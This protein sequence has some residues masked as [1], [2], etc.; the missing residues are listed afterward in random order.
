ME[1]DHLPASVATLYAELL[2]Q[3]IAHER[4]AGLEGQLPGGL[5]SKE[6][7]GKRYLYWQ[8]R[9]GNQV[10]QRYLGP[11]SQDLREALD[12][13]ADKRQDSARQRAS[14]ERL[15][16]MLI[17]GGALREQPRVAAVLRL[18]ADLGLFRRGAVVVGTQAFRTYG[19][20]LSVRLPSTA[21]RTQDIDVAHGIDVALASTAE[22]APAVEA[23]L[24]TL[25]LLPVPGLHPRQP[26]T[27]FHLRGR[28]LRVDFLTPAPRRAKETPIPLPGL[29]LSAWPL[30]FLD[31]LIEDPV[32][33]VALDA[34]PVLLRVPRPG[35]YA[36]HK[37]WT[38]ATRPASEHAKATKDRAQAAA[39]ITVLA[40]ERPDDLREAYSALGRRR[41]ARQRVA[42]E[43]ARVAP[44]YRTWAS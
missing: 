23:S 20:M 32:P 29:G 38:A 12:R 18:L 40:S 3:E 22:E 25:G 43:L 15:A 5:V 41:S 10:A 35:R 2:D 17:K 27:S 13:L 6:V 21:L 28:E 30:E 31:Y 33:A 1:I 44:E 39:L 34:R 42:R 36:L 11:D 24:A 14:L 19:N 9:K 8:V 16:A 7:R 37:L 26:S 4:T